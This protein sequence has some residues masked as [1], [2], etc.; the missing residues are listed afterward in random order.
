MRRWPFVRAPKSSVPRHWRL[1]LPAVA[2]TASIVAVGTVPHADAAPDGAGALQVPFDPSTVPQHVLDDETIEVTP[3]G[4][5][6]SEPEM[7]VGWPEALVEQVVAAEAAAAPAGSRSGEAEA[8]SASMAFDLHS[9]PD[10][11]LTIYLDFDGHVTTGTEWNRQSG[12]PSTF[13][14]APYSR[15][16]STAFNQTELEYIGQIWELVAEDYAPFD[17]DVTTEEPDFDELWRADGNDAEYGTRVVI[18][19]TNSWY[20]GSGGVAY[21]GSFSWQNVRTPAPDNEPV[22]TPAFVFSDSLGGGWP[23]FVAEAASH[24]AGHTLGL[25]HDGY[26]SSAYYP[27]HDITGSGD[28]KWA[29]IMGVGYDSDLTQWSGGEYAGANQTQDDIAIISSRL[30]WHS[31]GSSTVGYPTLTDGNSV[32][33]IVERST[34]PVDVDISVPAGRAQITI[35]PSVPDSNLVVKAQLLSGSTVLDEVTPT[36]AVDWTLDF[37]EV[38]AAGNYTVRLTSI[39]WGGPSNGFVSAGSIGQFRMELAVTPQGSGGTTTTPGTTTPGTTVP[40]DHSLTASSPAGCTAESRG[41]LIGF[42][43]QQAADTCFATAQRLG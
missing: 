17:V 43:E 13:T 42:G 40:P 23:K 34:A 20:G 4:L 41:G 7:F 9:K 26:S 12:R 3:V 32:E 16:A 29:P 28:D 10:A 35:E 36:R 30:G 6:V 14:S 5:L 19:P 24:E 21:I 25:L 8:P 38:L 39:G 37:D 33:G 22:V 11:D 2:V 1:A 18:S 27:G 31:A 15:D